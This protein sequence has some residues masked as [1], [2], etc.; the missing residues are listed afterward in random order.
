VYKVFT[1]V[2]WNMFFRISIS[3]VIFYLNLGILKVLAILIYC[4]FSL[5]Y[6]PVSNCVFFRFTYMSIFCNIRLSFFFSHYCPLY[7]IILKCSYSCVLTFSAYFFTDNVLNP[8]I[9]KQAGLN[10]FMNAED[11]ES[12]TVRLLLLY[13]EELVYE[14]LEN[15]RATSSKVSPEAETTHLCVA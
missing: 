5:P 2:L 15:E 1:P 12:S 4:S 8:H 7:T 3:V 9:F 14:E 11:E 13:I 10:F 6:F